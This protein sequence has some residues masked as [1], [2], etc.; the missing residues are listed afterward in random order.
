MSILCLRALFTDMLMVSK[1][2][3]YQFLQ[4]AIWETI[5][6]C[7]KIKHFLTREHLV[8]DG[9]FYVKGITRCVGISTGT[10]FRYQNS[11]KIFLIGCF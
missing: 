1:K 9:C 10:L 11:K 7:N 2:I 5:F 6:C 3:G 8:N 4:Q